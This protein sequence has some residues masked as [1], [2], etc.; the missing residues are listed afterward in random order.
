MARNIRQWEWI[1]AHGLAAHLPR[2]KMIGDLYYPAWNNH[3]YLISLGRM[4][5]K[6]Y[7]QKKWL[8]RISLSHYFSR[9]FKQRFISAYSPLIFVWVDCPSLVLNQ[10]F[11][12]IYSP[13]ILNCMG[14]SACT[15]DCPGYRQY[16]SLK[17]FDHGKVY[18]RRRAEARCAEIISA[19]LGSAWHASVLDEENIA[20]LKQLYWWYLIK[21]NFKVKENINNNLSN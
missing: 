12:A 8:R 20:V 3:I 16:I 10:C 21:D 14:C 15:H 11:I 2:P 18:F 7:G 13:L 1:Y 6:F 19:P 17:L 5:V 4:R 9:P